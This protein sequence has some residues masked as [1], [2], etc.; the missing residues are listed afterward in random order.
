MIS[1]QRRTGRRGVAL[2]IAISVLGILT[3][4]AMGLA[5]SQQVTRDL[6]A[7][8]SVRAKAL[9]SAQL[10]LD[11]A[12]ASIPKGLTKGHAAA[13]SDTPFSWRAQTASPDAA[14]YATEYLAHRPGD[15][16]VTVSGLAPT[17]KGSILAERQ[18]LVNLQ[19]GTERR[20][21]L[22]ETVSTERIGESISSEATVAP[23]AE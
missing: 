1:D 3:I 21:C 14:C 23:T 7:N 6:T 5:A 9:R 19:P 10:G 2:L 15:M 18:Y 13:Q 22:S 4:L 8:R 20:V 12:I 16:I 17:R 11:I